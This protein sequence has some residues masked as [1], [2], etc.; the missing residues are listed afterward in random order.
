M[1]LAAIYPLSEKS[2]VNLG[3]KVRVILPPSLYTN[4]ETVLKHIGEHIEYHR[5]RRRGTVCGE[6]AAATE[7]T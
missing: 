1:F 2:A 6:A 3:G 5:L 7:R 4:K